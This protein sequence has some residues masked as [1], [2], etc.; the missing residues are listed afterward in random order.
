MSR[1]SLRIPAVLRSGV[2]V[3]LAG[4]MVVGA[5]AAETP[6]AGGAAANGALS[7]TTD[8]VNAEVFVDGRSAG[9]T[10]TNLVS[11]PAGEHRVRIVKTGYLENA[12]VVTVSAGQPTIVNVKLTK[13]S[14]ATLSEGAGQVSST[15]RKSTRLNSSHLG[16]SYAVFCLKN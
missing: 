11:I 4:L 7:I 12:R 5:G 3:A 13:T 10:P 14:A 16:I 6:K 9:Q 15:D 8:P 1:S 2:S